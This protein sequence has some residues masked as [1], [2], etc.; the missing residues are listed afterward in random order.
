MSKADGKPTTGEYGVRR[1]V[2]SLS[3]LL[4][5]LTIAGV[6]LYILL[7]RAYAEFYDA[8]GLTPEDLGFGYV[9]ILGRSVGAISFIVVPAAAIAHFVN[10]PRD[11]GPAVA[12][13]LS[14]GSFL[15]ALLLGEWLLTAAALAVIGL[16]IRL[17]VHKLA[18]WL[19]TFII[20]VLTTL[21]LL[22]GLDLLTRYAELQA[23]T[24]R[25]G[26]AARQLDAWWGIPLL[27]LRGAPVEVEAQQVS[28]TVDCAMYL[29]ANDGST[30][31]YDVERGET[32]VIASSRVVVHLSAGE[33]DLGPDCRD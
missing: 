7:R 9:E 24:V 18:E 25:D 10:L 20:V 29:G 30:F 31:L 13:V 1:F 2:K 16:Q 33:D 21:I 32:V 4:P 14:V 5:L 8:F 26:V 6:C 28:D 27:E 22:R 23:A 17:R 12:W 15:F 3:P 11:Q 19:G